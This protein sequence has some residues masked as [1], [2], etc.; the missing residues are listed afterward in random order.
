MFLALALW[1]RLGLHELLTELM[2]PRREEIAWADAAAVL[3]EG[4]LCRQASELGIAEE[5]YTRTVARNATCSVAA[6]PAEPKSGPCLKPCRRPSAPRRS[7][8]SSRVMRLGFQNPEKQPQTI[9][10][11]ISFVFYLLQ[12]PEVNFL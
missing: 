8:T 6:A 12:R 1:R 4:K 11:E 10:A 5:W 2:E 9:T 7:Y 3:T